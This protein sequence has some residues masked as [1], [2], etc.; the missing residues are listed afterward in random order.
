MGAVICDFI[1]NMGANIQ[2]PV[3]LERIYD[4]IGQVCMPLLGFDY[5]EHADTCGL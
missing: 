5:R 4:N 3:A 1:Q 2:N